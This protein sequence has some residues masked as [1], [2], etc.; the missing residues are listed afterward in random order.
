MEVSISSKIDEALKLTG[1]RR[2]GIFLPR[3]GVERTE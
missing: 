2:E 3:N 1:T